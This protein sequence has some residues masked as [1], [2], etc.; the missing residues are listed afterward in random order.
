VTDKTIDFAVST[1]GSIWL[2][3]PLTKDAREHAIE[4]F[5]EETPTFGLGYAVEHRYAPEI[6]DAM[7]HGGW[8]VELDG[9]VL[10]LRVTH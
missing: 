9:H 10:E 1:H 8:H 5:P 3:E 6:V 2:F 7:L 4:N